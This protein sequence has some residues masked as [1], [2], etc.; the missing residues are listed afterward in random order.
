MRAL[1]VEAGLAVVVAGPG[2]SVVTVP[3]RRRRGGWCAVEGDAV[4][5]AIDS[6]GADAVV[7]ARA[8]GDDPGATCLPALARLL[9]VP[10]VRLP[11][12]TLLAGWVLAVAAHPQFGDADLVRR[13]EVLVGAAT[14]VGLPRRSVGDGPRVPALRPRV[15]A[16]WAGCV[17]RPCARCAGGGLMGAACGRC[18]APRLGL[19]T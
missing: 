17:W 3:R 9:G 6:A 18:G 1:V 19:V 5:A 16:R 8:P 15:L 7:L 4:V 13:L 2:R 11:A 14:A 10:A 12:D